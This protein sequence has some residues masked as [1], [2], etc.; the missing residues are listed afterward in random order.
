MDVICDK[1]TLPVQVRWMIRK[2]LDR[3][4]LIENGSFE[5]PWTEEDFRSC[6][7]QRNCIAMV[8]EDRNDMIVGFVVYELLK[9]TIHILNLAADPRYR[10]EDVGTAI[11]DRMIAKLSQQRRTEIIVEVRETNLTA[12]LFFRSQGFVATQV[13]RTYY[14]DCDDDAYQFCYSLPVHDES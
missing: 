10:R 12:H 9:D 4:L 1:L 13:I 6:L 11:I 14:D 5:F 2:D 7:R 3:V 8:A